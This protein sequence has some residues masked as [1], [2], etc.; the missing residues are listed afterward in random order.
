M[1][2]IPLLYVGHPPVPPRGRVRP[3]YREHGFTKQALDHPVWRRPGGRY[4]NDA[5]MLT[6]SRLSLARK[7]RG[8]TAADLA[9]AVGVSP[10]SMGDYE[11]GRRHPGDD[12]IAAFAEVL[13]FPAEFFEAP[14][15]VELPEGAVTFRAA[16]KLPKVRRAAAIAA[17]QLATEF[18]RWLEHTFT[19]PEPDLPL[20]PMGTDPE[21]A[22]EMVR[23]SWNVGTGA[24]P[25]LVHLLE[26]H[27]VRVFSLPVDCAEVDAFSFWHEGTPFVFLNPTTSPEQGRVDAAHEL[28]HLVL[29]T[30]GPYWHAE[31]LAN[32]FSRAFLMPRAGVLSTVPPGIS[33]KQQVL[34]YRKHWLVSALAMAERLDELDLV[35]TEQHLALLL[36]FY[37][38]S[39]RKA[40]P[41]GI[42]SR[43]G[44][45]LLTKVFRTLRE[46]GS[47]P[48]QVAQELLMDADELHS[49]LFGLVVTALPG[50]G[51]ST[52]SATRPKLTLVR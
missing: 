5:T 8:L 14:G 28:G 6:P 3:G 45:L 18:N 39:Y 20:Y 36:A 30:D 24:A 37:H 29:P 47:S 52:P 50:A 15:L 10:S 33:T 48:H 44:S 7:R 42:V 38:R 13:G 25:N 12:K 31:R 16:A 11:R 1:A 51:E 26:K 41:D 4:Q 2:R 19:L 32:T 46:G 43:E 35:T 40:E 23:A 49:L 22:A 21:T 17:A 27:G 9:R 34:S